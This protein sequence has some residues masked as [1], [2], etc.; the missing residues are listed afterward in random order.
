[1]GKNV[2]NSNIQRPGRSDRSINIIA[3][4]IVFIATLTLLNA[5]TQSVHVSTPVA[6][7]LSA[8]PTLFLQARAESRRREFEN[9]WPEVLDLIISGIQSGLSL[10]QTLNSL[11]ARGPARIH[12][13]FQR[14]SENLKSGNSF[15]S[16]LHRL[17]TE[18]A[19]PLS[20]QVCE[21][22]R[23]AQN[24]GSS[25]TA[26]T[27]RTYADFVSTDLLLNEEIRAKHAWIR[28][29]ALLASATPWFLLIL[30][31]TQSNARIAYSSPSG[32]AVL[33]VGVCL[34]TIAFFWMNKV[35]N[36]PRPPRIF[37]K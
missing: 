13:N 4:P 6:I 3:T 17:K 22:L 28:N 29:T 16:S 21:V 12:G 8:V 10:S 2:E 27:L 30:L 7:V 24:S 31:S 15:E 19:H 26:L 5:L 33:M 14:F 11:S 37:R 18:F 35:G 32:F 25:N 23:I 20:D 9:L 1:M 36:V 34:T